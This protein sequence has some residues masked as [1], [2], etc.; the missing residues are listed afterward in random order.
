MSNPNIDRII[1]DIDGGLQ[2]AGE[3]PADAVASIEGSVWADLVADVKAGWLPAAEAEQM[4]ADWRTRWLGGT[5][6][7]G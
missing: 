6:L 5:A 7:N 3:L 2:A 1:G 4:F